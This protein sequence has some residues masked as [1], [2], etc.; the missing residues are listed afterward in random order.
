MGGL[1]LAGPLGID[2]RLRSLRPCQQNAAFLKGFADRRDPETQSRRV[3]PLAA[4][5]KLGPRDD[6]LIALVDAAAGKH[7]RARI[8]VDL[9]MA[10]HHEDFYFARC[11]GTVT[12]QQDGR[13]GAWRVR[14]T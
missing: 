1:D 4:T 2:Q 6:L 5:V 14:S 9:I 11:R 3:E 8:K 7:Q 10:D 13:R 12:Q